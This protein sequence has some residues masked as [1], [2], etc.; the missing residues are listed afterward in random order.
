[1]VRRTRVGT[2]VLADGTLLRRN[3]PDQLRMIKLAEEEM[4]Q[5][6][7]VE[8][9]VDCRRTGSGALEYLVKWRGYFTVLG[10]F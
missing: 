4:P 7:E 6:F 9:R 8:V 2:Y 3:A 5:T 1:M 10:D